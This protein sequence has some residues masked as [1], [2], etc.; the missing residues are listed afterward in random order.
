MTAKPKTRRVTYTGSHDP[1][2]VVDAGVSVRPGETI[3][4]AAEVADRLLAQT[5]NWRTARRKRSD[6][7]EQ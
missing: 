7:Q 3:T 5:T 2:Y 1:A 6:D 4:V